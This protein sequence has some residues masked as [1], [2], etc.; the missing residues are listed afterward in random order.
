MFINRK[1]WS[2]KE[3]MEESEIDL[4]QGE[5]IF[6]IYFLSHPGQ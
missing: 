6:N 2:L 3:K 5:E 1:K 4:D